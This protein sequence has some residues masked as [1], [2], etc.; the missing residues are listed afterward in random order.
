MWC[1]LVILV[2]HLVWFKQKRSGRD[3]STTEQPCLLQPLLHPLSQCKVICVGKCKW[4]LREKESWSW[5]IAAG[6][7][8]GYKWI[9]SVLYCTLLTLSILRAVSHFYRL[10]YLTKK[11]NRPWDISEWQDECWWAN[12][13]R[14]TSVSLLLQNEA[15]ML[16]CV[17]VC[18]RTD[19]LICLWC[20][21][22][23]KTLCRDDAAQTAAGE[24]KEKVA[25]GKRER[26][27]FDF[28]FCSPASTE[29]LVSLVTELSSIHS[30]YMMAGVQWRGELKDK[31]LTR[32]EVLFR[33]LTDSIE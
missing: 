21:F 18:T 29:H 16:C 3:L 30:G 9:D 14:K 6:F 8:Q 27:R 10:R 25:S 13:F 24:K 15:H 32:P 12:R 23:L 31:C 19:W 33:H 1:L 28:L 26:E 22:Q 7:G 4:S 11:K 17:R 2:L 20:K 5:A